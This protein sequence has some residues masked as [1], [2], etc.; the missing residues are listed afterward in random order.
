MTEEENIAFRVGNKR[1]T[2]HTKN[3][4]NVLLQTTQVVL[5]IMLIAK[6]ELH[7][8]PPYLSSIPSDPV[9]CTPDLNH[10]NYNALDW[11]KRVWLASQTHQR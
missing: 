8:L 10:C 5:S 2:G 1:K 11:L 6:S 4:Q 3:D 7:F 9:S